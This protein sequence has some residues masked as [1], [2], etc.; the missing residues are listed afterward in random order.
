MPKNGEIAFVHYYEEQSGSDLVKR[1]KGSP[2]KSTIVG[3]EY[4]EEGIMYTVCHVTDDF[5]HVSHISDFVVMGDDSY[6]R[7]K[8][9]AKADNLAHK[10]WLRIMDEF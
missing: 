10:A 5:M 8:Q 4:K 6:P 9:I 3:M 1:A 7:M 2:F